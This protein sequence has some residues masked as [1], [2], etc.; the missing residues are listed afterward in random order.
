[1]P[2]SVQNGHSL[3]TTYLVTLYTH[4][5]S[6]L[7]PFL[8]IRLYGSVYFLG[9]FT[10]VPIVCY[11]A[12]MLLAQ[13]PRVIVREYERN[14][15][16]L[17]MTIVRVIVYIVSI[18]RIQH[19]PPLH[20]LHALRSSGLYSILLQSPEGHPHISQSDLSVPVLH[21]TISV[22]QSECVTN[23]PIETSQGVLLP[24]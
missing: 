13:R 11:L 24:L 2:H 7:S 23:T 20:L 16:H 3:P 5:L 15:Y 10:L 21:L 1:M 19:Q 22:Y 12:A 17:Q 14:L 4:A 8:V 6:V 9:S 18:R